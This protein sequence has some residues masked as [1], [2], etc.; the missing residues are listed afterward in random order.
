MNLL[1]IQ[2]RKF[3]IM[4][5][6]LHYA[7]ATPIFWHNIPVRAIERQ[8]E[9]TAHNGYGPFASSV[10]VH[11]RQKCKTRSRNS[12]KIP[13]FTF[14]IMIV[15]AMLSRKMTPKSGSILSKFFDCFIVHPESL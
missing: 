9:Q 15:L 4:S 1:I 10:V 7:G 2:I 13:K 12:E 14:K 3:T 6:V 11:G 8:R 5:G